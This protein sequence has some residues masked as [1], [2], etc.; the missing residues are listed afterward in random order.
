[1]GLNVYAYGWRDYDPAIGRFLKIDRFAEKYSPLSPYSYTANNPVLFVD[2]AGDSIGAGK[3][4]FKRFRDNVLDMINKINLER[5]N[6]ISI[7]YGKGDIFGAQ[8]LE[9]A[10]AKEDSKIDSKMRILNET[11]KELN[12]LEASS[13]IYNLF[14]G[15]EDVSLK[16][17]GNVKYDI[18]THELNINLRKGFDMGNFAHELKHAYQFQVGQLSFNTTGQGGGHLY[19]SHDEYAAYSRGA[20]FGGRFLRND[21]IDQTYNLKKGPVDLNSISPRT[22]LT[23]REEFK[24]RTQYSSSNGTAQKQFYINWKNDTKK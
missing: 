1:M 16:A 21:E 11:L 7:L 8:K 2:I 6:E 14:V 12:F 23:Y 17:L 13:Q 22:Q 3:D 4:H 9:Q 19:D 15:S 24:K 20:F 18:V 10:F 5:E